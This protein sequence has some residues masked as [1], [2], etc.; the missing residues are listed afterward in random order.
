MFLSKAAPQLKCRA[1]CALESYHALKFRHK[2]T[3]RLVGGTIV[4]PSCSVNEIQ[5]E[6]RGPAARH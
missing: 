2:R 6:L 4:S 1:Y 3:V 5:F